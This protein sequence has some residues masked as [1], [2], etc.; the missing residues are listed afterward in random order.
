VAFL[1][2]APAFVI[3]AGDPFTGTGPVQVAGRFFFGVAGWCC[4]VALLGLLDRPAS[5]SRSPARS[6]AP[7][8]L[9]AYLAAAALPY[10]VLHQPIVVAVAYGV[11]PWDAPI[12]V[13]YLVIVAISL[14]LTLGAYEVLVRRT[15]VTRFLFGMREPVSDRAMS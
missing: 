6:P 5:A 11:V 9:Y 14:A 7:K 15:R 4:L 12:I 13:E 3:A 1:A 10:Y 2:S 8:R